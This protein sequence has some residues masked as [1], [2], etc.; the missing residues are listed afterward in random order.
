MQEAP[1][2]GRYIDLTSTPVSLPSASCFISIDT[3]FPP[4]TSL[5]CAQYWHIKR[6]YMIFAVQNECTEGLVVLCFWLNDYKV[7]CIYFHHT[8]HEGSFVPKDGMNFTKWLASE[9]SSIT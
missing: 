3:G 8:L 7:F 6:I 4:L 9:H 2:N 5:L 1:F